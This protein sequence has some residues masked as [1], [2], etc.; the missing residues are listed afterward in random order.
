VNYSFKRDLRAT[1]EGE[2][3]NYDNVPVF[4][5]LVLLLILIS[6]NSKKAHEKHVGSV[7]AGHFLIR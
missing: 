2:M 4:G 3:T 6:I 1:V 5:E 7:E